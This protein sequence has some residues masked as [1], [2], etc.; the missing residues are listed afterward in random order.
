MPKLFGR[1][2]AAFVDARIEIDDMQPGA[3]VAFMMIVTSPWLL[4][5]QT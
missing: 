4:K 5:A 1:V 3:P 2:S